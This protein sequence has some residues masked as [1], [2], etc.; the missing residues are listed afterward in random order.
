[1]LGQPSNPISLNRYLY[2]NANPLSYIDP[3][4]HQVS[5]LAHTPTGPP[6]Q[7]NLGSIEG[8]TKE[9]IREHALE[10]VHERIWSLSQPVVIVDSSGGGG[11]GDDP[12]DPAALLS[13]AFGDAVNNLV[14]GVQSI[15]G[16]VGAWVSQQWN[17]LENVPVIGAVARAATDVV[18]ACTGSSLCEGA[19]IIGIAIVCPECVV[20]GLINGA[21]GAA[22][23]KDVLGSILQGEAFAGVGKVLSGLGELAGGLGSKGSDVAG[24][25]F[26]KGSAP[27]V[28]RSL[29][30]FEDGELKATTTEVGPASGE[31]KSIEEAA[32]NGERAAAADTEAGPAIEP[33][34]PVSPESPPPEPSGRSGPENGPGATCGVGQSFTPATEVRLADGTSLPLD[35]IKVGDKVLATDPT[36]GKTQAE[37]VTAVWINH[38]SDLLNL[39]VHTASGDTVIDTTQHHLF[40]DLTTHQWVPAQRLHRGDRLYAP[41]G[42]VATVVYAKVV[43]GAVDMWDLTVANDHDFYID[44]FSVDLL[45]HNNDGDCEPTLF[46][47][48]YPEDQ[49]EPFQR[50]APSVAL[51]RSGRYSYVV[52]RDGR[53]VIG[54]ANVVGHIDLAEGAK[55]VQAAGE[56]QTKGGEVI[57]INNASGHYWPSGPN[58]QL[59][60]FGAFQRYG[61]TV[62]PGVYNEVDAEG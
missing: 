32:A 40:Y 45:V 5:A 11:S 20:P 16:G 31:A 26:G 29:D 6:V 62:P 46:P 48:R 52:T 7:T 61:I 36:T 57:N 44:T 41:N 33:E 55:F 30:A 17:N 56:F 59:Q 12:F 9:Q 47:N 22:T 21:I 8:G 2:A 60:A 50:I 18:T 23:G 3:T 34:S 25:L 19:A 39:T 42:V 28:S 24:D 14:S 37:P 54:R 43:P 1:M 27:E 15:A 51:E 4:G 38:D 49:P 35:K 10:Q 13:E 58:A 53:L